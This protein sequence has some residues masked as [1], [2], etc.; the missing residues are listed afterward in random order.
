M[1]VITPGDPLAP[2][3]TGTCHR[4][5][6]LFLC[7]RSEAAW[8]DSPCRTDGRWLADCPTCEG[9]GVYVRVPMTPAPGDH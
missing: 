5:G 9:W 8:A 6:C 2:T 7:D 1:T 3:L 4:C